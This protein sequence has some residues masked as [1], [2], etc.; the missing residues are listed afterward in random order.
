MSGH[1][2]GKLIRQARK[3]SNKTFKEIENYMG[4]SKSYQINLEL[5]KGSIPPL[6]TLVRLFDFLNENIDQVLLIVKKELKKELFVKINYFDLDVSEQNS[7]FRL[8]RK[9]DLGYKQK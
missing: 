4:Y 7:I 8:I 5:G 6:Q 3:N 9:Y 1:Q 2:L